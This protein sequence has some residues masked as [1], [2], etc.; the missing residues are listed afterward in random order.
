MSPYTSTLGDHAWGGEGG[1][2]SVRGEERQAMA[3]TVYL[4]T[5][6]GGE[7]EEVAPVALRL[8]IVPVDSSRVQTLQ[9]WEANGATC[10]S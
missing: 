3:A 8:H 5:A 9:G 7:A 2:G 10:T 6:H 4:A 1:G